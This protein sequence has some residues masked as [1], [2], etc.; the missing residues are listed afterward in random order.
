MPYVAKLV[1]FALLVLLVLFVALV[2]CRRVCKK[3]IIAFESQ[4]GMIYIKDRAIVKCMLNSLNRIPDVRQTQAK[5]ENTPRGIVATVRAN[6]RITA[7]ELPDLKRQ[8]SESVEDTLTRVIGISNVSDI[9][10]FIEDI[11]LSGSET[12]PKGPDKPTAPP[13]FSIDQEGTDAL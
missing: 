3:D 1:A 9:K 11:E 6:V 7:G 5:I 2:S 13:E 12:K 10:V 8:M 4:D